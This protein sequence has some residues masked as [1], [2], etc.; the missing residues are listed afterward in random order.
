MENRVRYPQQVFRIKGRFYDNRTGWLYELIPD[1]QE[2]QMIQ[3]ANLELLE[4]IPEYPGPREESAIYLRE[5]FFPY[6]CRKNDLCAKTFETLAERSDHELQGRCQFEADLFDRSFQ[7]G[8][9][10]QRRH[11]PFCRHTDCT[12]SFP[13]LQARDE[14]EKDKCPYGLTGGLRAAPAGPSTETIKQADPINEPTT[15]EDSTNDTRSEPAVDVDPSGVKTK[16]IQSKFR[17]G[18][19]V[20]V[21]F[22][23]EGKDFLP[24]VK[25]KR[26]ALTVAKARYDAVKDVWEYRFVE[27]GGPVYQGEWIRENRLSMKRQGPLWISKAKDTS[28]T[29]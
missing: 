17:E 21:E 4:A 27:D 5:S 25:R 24:G 9:S 26:F 28:R 16:L 20:L 6:I 8:L 1:F 2:G 19:T 22:T 13:T 10:I 29:R 11:D 7:L 23:E 15:Q 14:H 12:E 18:D 3:E